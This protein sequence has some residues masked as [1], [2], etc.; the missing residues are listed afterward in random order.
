MANQNRLVLRQ[1]DTVIGRI[2]DLGKIISNTPL[3]DLCGHIH[4]SRGA[5]KIKKT[6]VVNPESEYTEGILRGVI[7]NLADKK[8]A[9]WQMTS[10]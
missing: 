6:L 3:V 9:S 8:V 5:C 10:G 2:S 4:E 7:V 1:C